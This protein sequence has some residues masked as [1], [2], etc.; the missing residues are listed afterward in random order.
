MIR[1]PSADQDVV[2]DGMPDW[3]REA[4]AAAKHADEQNQ[5]TFVRS[6]VYDGSEV[7]RL[8]REMG[9]QGQEDVFLTFS[10]WWGRPFTIPSR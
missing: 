9:P 3:I 2:R 6:D 5:E 8:W 1:F 10:L 4:R 7:R